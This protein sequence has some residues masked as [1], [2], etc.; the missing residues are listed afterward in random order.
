MNPL[1]RTLS[2]SGT[3][4]RVPPSVLKVSPR[5]G[6]LYPGQSV[7]VTVSFTAHTPSLSVNEELEVVTRGGVTRFITIRGFSSSP[8]VTV[9]N[10]IVAFKPQ[11]VG[12]VATAIVNLKNHS[13]QHVAFDVTVETPSTNQLPETAPKAKNRSILAQTGVFETE[14]RSPFHPPRPPFRVVP[15]VGTI[16]PCISQTLSI[17][18]RPDTFIPSFPASALLLVRIASGNPVPILVT[19]SILPNET[20]ESVVDKLAT[21][22]SPQGRP[23]DNPEDEASDHQLLMSSTASLGKM[24][25]ADDI[26]SVRTGV[27]LSIERPAPISP[28]YVIVSSEIRRL[29][30]F[31]DLV[32][33]LDP[34]K[35]GGRVAENSA[36]YNPSL[37]EFAPDN[38]WAGNEHDLADK[39]EYAVGSIAKKIQNP[40]KTRRFAYDS[41]LRFFELGSAFSHML[42]GDISQYTGDS[43]LSFSNTAFN[44]G[45][46]EHTGGSGFS[47]KFSRRTTVVK[48]NSNIPFRLI[49]TV[50]AGPFSRGSFS[51]TPQ[52][53]VIPAKSETEMKLEFRPARPGAEFGSTV[54]IFAYPEPLISYRALVN[55]YVPAPQRF[56][57]FLIGRSCSPPHANEALLPNVSF[58]FGFRCFKSFV[59]LR[60]CPVGALTH[61]TVPLLNEMDAA[62]TFQVERFDPMIGQWRQISN[63]FDT[64]DSNKSSDVF[65]AVYPPCG[66]IRPHSTSLLTFVGIPQ[67]DCRKIFQLRI[68]VGGA[69]AKMNT[70]E[71]NVC[72]IAEAPA[73]AI[74]NTLDK[75]IAN[76]FGQNRISFGSG[77]IDPT[78]LEMTGL[79]ASLDKPVPPATFILPKTSLNTSSTATIKLRSQSSV[80][81][82]LNFFPNPGSALSFNPPH[83]PLM[84]FDS[85][86]AALTLLALSKKIHTGNFS[87]IVS[88]IATPGAGEVEIPLSFLKGLTLS[89]RE[90][91]SFEQSKLMT[92]ASALHTLEEEDSGQQLDRPDICSIF[93]ELLDMP[94]N[95]DIRLS[96]SLFTEISRQT[97]ASLNICSFIYP[98]S[99]SFEPGTLQGGSLLVGKKQVFEIKMKNHTQT[100]IPFQLFAS[101][102]LP[103]KRAGDIGLSSFPNDSEVAPNFFE[104]LADVTLD[105]KRQD[106]PLLKREHGRISLSPNSEIR[107]QLSIT[108]RQR[109][110]FQINFGATLD[111]LSS[112]SRNLTRQ[113]QKTVLEKTRDGT[114]K[115]ELETVAIVSQFEPNEELFDEDASTIH[116]HFEATGELPYIQITAMSSPTVPVTELLDSMNLNTFNQFLKGKVS[117]VESQIRDGA[118]ML[119]TPTGESL[120][121]SLE[122]FSVALGPGYVL[123]KSKTASTL[124]EK[125]CSDNFTTFVFDVMNP[126]SVSVKMS[127]F[128]PSERQPNFESS[129][130]ARQAPTKKDELLRELVS[131]DIFHIW[132]REI[133]IKPG[134]IEHFYVQYRHLRPS[135]DDLKV[136]VDIKNGR[137]FVLDLVGQT[138]AQSEPA[139]LFP[140]AL[141]LFPPPLRQSH[142]PLNYLR[143]KNPSDTPCTY[144][145]DTSPILELN[146]EMGSVGRPVLICENPIGTIPPHQ[147]AN[148]RFTFTPSL[149]DRFRIFLPVYLLENEGEIKALLSCGTVETI[150]DKPVDTKKFRVQ[151]HEVL[152]SN[153]TPKVRLAPSSACPSPAPGRPPSARPPSRFQNVLNERA[154]RSTLDSAD[155]TRDFTT[156]NSPVPF[157]PTRPQKSEKSRP[158]SA[159]FPLPLPPLTSDSRLNT[160]GKIL[161]IQFPDQVALAPSLPAFFVPEGPIYTT[162]TI[163]GEAIQGI[164][165]ADIGGGAPDQESV[166]GV[167]NETFSFQAGAELVSNPPD[168]V[169][170]VGETNTQAATQFSV[171]PIDESKAVY[172]KPLAPHIPLVLPSVLALPEVPDNPFL[173]LPALPR[174]HFGSLPECEY[175]QLSAGRLVLGA[176]PTLS[177]TE[178]TFSIHVP[179]KL[180]EEVERRP[181]LCDM[182]KP[183]SRAQSGSSKRAN[184]SEKRVPLV[185]WAVVSPKLLHPENKGRAGRISFTPTS[186]H[187][188]PGQSAIIRVSLDTGPVAMVV[189]EDIEVQLALSSTSLRR[190]MSTMSRQQELSGRNLPHVSSS[191]SMYESDAHSFGD[192]PTSSPSPRL[193]TF[194]EKQKPFNPLDES[195]FTNGSEEDEGGEEIFGMSFAAN[196]QREVLGDARRPQGAKARTT[197]KARKKELLQTAIRRADAPTKSGDNSRKKHNEIKRS[198]TLRQTVSSRI[199][200][201]KQGSRFGFDSDRTVRAGHGTSA[202][203]EFAIREGVRLSESA[204]SGPLSAPS[205]PKIYTETSL[206]I[207]LSFH[208]ELDAEIALFAEQALPATTQAYFPVIPLAAIPEDLFTAPPVRGWLKANTPR[209]AIEKFANQSIE[210]AGEVVPPAMDYVNDLVQSVLEEQEMPIE[211]IT[212]ALSDQEDNKAFG[213]QAFNAAFAALEAFDWDAVHRE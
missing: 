93:K 152:R 33:P 181:E 50:S 5:A 12:H 190:Y 32:R 62:H 53:L 58:Q 115:T 99:V 198:V 64:F 130:W 27:Q 47:D 167:E 80:P 185:S 208:T 173:L 127:M 77:V 17:E 144:L 206:W 179:K 49:V 90:T 187:L 18:F 175:G 86:S 85:N 109:G 178:T 84:P 111:T 165:L 108:V 73:A 138:L 26:T 69:F 74:E 191:L 166:G 128:L 204:T 23:I 61:A 8:K 192:A 124:A 39:M 78:F 1:Q 81:W 135:I 170:T 151:D 139:L 201:H 59:M 46:V 148:I 209:Q 40:G 132:P 91:E 195:S 16:R 136:L 162:I 197:L 200:A 76:T 89:L 94:Q 66:I 103:V 96:T 22:R 171:E 45:F 9:D 121:E 107:L 141:H 172:L 100:Y 42:L 36:L 14:A 72:V 52:H 95:K 112:V 102:A 117:E 146:Q 123:Q 37:P 211:K 105:I 184:I 57:M 25:A 31:A 207:T 51:I 21:M 210:E 168:P 180:Q 34:A 156:K 205:R 29:R 110:D 65:L 43:L 163:T 161:C 30:D 10:P 129:P 28:E 120:L 183:K 83:I 213:I 20:K 176:L 174:L 41:V 15:D 154:A 68:V 125:E 126:S 92:F 55:C 114:S 131:N 24:L 202:R 153:P 60:P 140:I 212:R 196:K 149:P 79:H 70:R 113:R 150:G 137:M 119:I 118:G 157:S 145:V 194:V 164:G 88:I 158:G 7:R 13:N 160:P 54:D 147:T 87:E 19:G 11:K 82:F 98:R 104:K 106:F 44:F 48:N 122:S 101:E 143:V 35:K 133:C 186:G 189:E 182:L 97:V 38:T 56:Q 193:E 6:E 2:H 3:E 199:R 116:G 159:A 203:K 4:K 71:V 67:K 75:T 134:E 155:N 177:H 142:T 63:N 169:P 188:Y